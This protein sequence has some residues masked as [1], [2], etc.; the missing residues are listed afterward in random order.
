MKNAGLA[1]PSSWATAAV[2]VGLIL[3]GGILFACSYRS[4]AGADATGY[5]NIARSL[6]SGRITQPVAGLDE[7]KLPD[8]FAYALCPLGYEVASQRRRMSPIYPVGL[9]LHMAAGALIA[10]WERGPFWISPVAALVSLILM[11]FVA[12]ELGLSQGL[13][14]AAAAMLAANPTFFLCALQPMSDG[15]ATCWSLGAVLAVLKS[16]K[17]EALGLASGAA[18]GV[19][20]LVR[21]TSVLLVPALAVVLIQGGRRIA[22]Y[23]IA[24]LLP[25]LAVFL[26]Y[27][28]IVSGHILESGYQRLNLSGLITT[29]GSAVRLGYYL[30]WLIVLMSPVPLL[31]WLAAGLIRRVALPDRLFLIIW[32]GS[33]LVFYACYSFYHEW[34]YTRFLLPGIPA[35][36]LGSLLTI[37]GIGA[38]RVLTA[39]LLAIVLA[40]ERQGV[41]HFRLL[42]VGGIEMNNADSC[43][44]A[45]DIVPAKVM[46]VAMEMSGGVKYYTGRPV[47]RYERLSLDQWS[48]LR[49]H[50]EAQRYGFYAL[51]KES[52]VEEAQ[53]RLPGEWVRL[54]SQRDVTLWQIM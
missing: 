12:L 2:L 20:F 16:R 54:G 30:Y 13:A 22:G 44:W 35:V 45:D 26:V 1:R 5:A 18:L 41:E 21:P 38:G 10:G 40:F 31:G 17:R 29:E 8:Q 9:P 32:F 48:E 34:W 52:E 24:G 36:F 49:S 47:V 19:A 27:N 51:L 39:L 14:V 11:Y 3:Y 25:S 43:R 23:V 6:V 7:L 42:K 15:L 37:H 50:A 33:F 28:N 4:V 53:R 46:I